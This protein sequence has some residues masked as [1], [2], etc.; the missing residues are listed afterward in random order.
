MRIGPFDLRGRVA[1]V[2]G[3]GSG[4]GR[5]IALGFAEHGADVVVTEVPARQAAAEQVVAEIHATGRRSLS[6]ALDVRRSPDIAAMVR[7]V[8]AEFTRIDV[9]VN[10]AG[11]SIFRDV[12]EVTE[13]EWDQQNDVNCKGAFFVSQAVAVEMRRL[14]GGRI[15]N[16]ASASGRLAHPELV[17]YCVSKA[18]IIMLTK[19][20]AVAL[21]PYNINVNAILP[22][23]CLTDQTRMFLQSEINL[24]V[25]LDDIPKRRLGRPED[26]AGAALYLA[27]AEADWTTGALLSVD[28]GLLRA[29]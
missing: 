14:G 12:L 8:M 11:V 20:M 29:T 2:T 7:R 4:I 16:I 5:A 17:P 28:G 21:A 13:E 24:R 3:S 19:A 6:V 18:G 25:S 23:T 15:I 9:L 26:I 27:S 22:G 1:V 10:N